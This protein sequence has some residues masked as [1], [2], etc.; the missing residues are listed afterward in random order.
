MKGVRI[1]GAVLAI[2]GA[3][4]LT[5]VFAIVYRGDGRFDAL[6]LGI[7]AILLAVWAGLAL[8]FRGASWLTRKRRDF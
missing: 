2:A 4:A 6:A 3:A 1:L 5:V 8:L 7:P